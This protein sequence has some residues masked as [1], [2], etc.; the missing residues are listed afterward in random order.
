MTAVPAIIH[1]ERRW[2]DIS[3]SNVVVAPHPRIVA[4]RWVGQAADECEQEWEI[5]PDYHVVGIA[6][7]PIGDLT[8]FSGG[9]LIGS[10]SRPRGSVR[11]NPP[12]QRLRGIFRGAYDVL[13]LH[14][15]NQT[16]DEYHDPDCTQLRTTPL[17]ADH[18]TVDLVIE[19]LASSL[20]YA[21]KL[22]GALGQS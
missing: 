6:L 17:I 12:G 22:G 8:V 13:H 4:S 18:L 20:I 2:F 10:G 7:Q 19:K 14:I 21:E 9:K 15:P 1:R 3:D 11:L 16:I 5:A